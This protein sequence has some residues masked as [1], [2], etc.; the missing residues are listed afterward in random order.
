METLKLNSSETAFQ[1]RLGL[2]PQMMR[3]LKESQQDYAAEGIQMTLEEVY[4]FEVETEPEE[5]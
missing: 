5:D 2:E 3:N 1:D 4:A